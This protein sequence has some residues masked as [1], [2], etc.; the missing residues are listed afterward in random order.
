MSR[1]RRKTAVMPITT[2]VSEKDYK[3]A[4]HRS[5]RRTVRT[6]LA[7]GSDDTAPKLHQ[8]YGNPWNGPKDGKQRI[9]PK[10]KWM[11]K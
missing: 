6:A 11:R 7:S 2:A 4:N 10:S 5:E 3:A 1:S 9:D 8:D